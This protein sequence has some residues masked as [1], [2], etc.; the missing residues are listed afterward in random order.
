MTTILAAF[1]LDGLFRY[2]GVLNN[3]TRIGSI[4]AA[5]GFLAYASAAVAFYVEG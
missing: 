1:V 3:P 2:F 4:L 5:I